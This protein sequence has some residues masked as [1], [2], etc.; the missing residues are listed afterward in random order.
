MTQRLRTGPGMIGYL[1]IL[2]I[3]AALAGSALT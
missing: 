1:L 2:A 3:F